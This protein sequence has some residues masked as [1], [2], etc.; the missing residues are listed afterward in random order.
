MLSTSDIAAI[1]ARIRAIEARTRAQVVVALV[2][3][4]DRFHGLRWRA[5]ALGAAAAAFVVVLLDVARPDWVTSR[6]AIVTAAAIIGAG[7]A[8]TVLATFMP[9]F[10]R[11]FLSWT[12]AQAE[13]RRRATS[14]FFERELFATPRRNAVLLLA[15]RFERAM[16]VVGDSAYRDRIDAAGW[17]RVVDAATAGMAAGDARKAFLAGLDALESL[18]VAQGFVGDG[19]AHND[20]PDRPLESDT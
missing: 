20:L 15:G 9:A 19:D 14:L 11:L 10:E 8:C 12:R 2:A 13:V 4:T 5:F 18:L 3:R 6:T 7:L 17:Q 16:A 1:E